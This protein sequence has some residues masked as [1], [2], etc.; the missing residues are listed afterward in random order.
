[1]NKWEHMALANASIAI[2]IYMFFINSYAG[3]SVYVIFSLLLCL[4]GNGSEVE[5]KEAATDPGT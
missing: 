2:I 4:R 3:I 5:Q 1:M